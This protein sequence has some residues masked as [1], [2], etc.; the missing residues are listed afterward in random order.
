MEIL[1]KDGK[2]K[3]TMPT[4]E[5]RGWRCPFNFETYCPGCVRPPNCCEHIENEGNIE[6]VCKRGYLQPAAQHYADRGKIIGKR[7]F[8]V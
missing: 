5:S 8:L 7:K 1:I 4:C 2:W 3:G 6:Y